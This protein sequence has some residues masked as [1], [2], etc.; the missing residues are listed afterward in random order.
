MTWCRG[1][2]RTDIPRP[3]EAGLGCRKKQ[4]PLRRQTLVSASAVARRLLRWVDPQDVSQQIG[5][6]GGAHSGSFRG[7]HLVLVW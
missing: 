1:T 4:L 2:G 3:L 5:V 7:K 6:A